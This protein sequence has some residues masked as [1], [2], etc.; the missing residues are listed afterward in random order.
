[1]APVALTSTGSDGSSGT[2]PLRPIRFVKLRKTVGGFLRNLLSDSSPGDSFVVTVG[3]GA[4]SKE[5]GRRPLLPIAPQ[6]M[7]RCAFEALDWWVAGVTLHRSRALFRTNSCPQLP[8]GNCL[9]VC[10]CNVAFFERNERN[11]RNHRCNVRPPRPGRSEG[12]RLLV[13]RATSA[14]KGCG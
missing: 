13:A 14:K 2:V 4:R 5:S 11:E 1:M 3:R 12:R 6:S 8:R 9:A 10:R 7:P